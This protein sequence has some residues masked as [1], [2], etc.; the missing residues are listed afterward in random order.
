MTEVKFG[1]E[2]KRAVLTASWLPYGKL[3]DTLE[4]ARDLRRKVSPRFETQLVKFTT[5]KFVVPEKNVN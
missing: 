4:E 5:A 1:V 3:V 2:A